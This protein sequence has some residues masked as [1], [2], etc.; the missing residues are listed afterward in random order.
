MDF[1]N[2]FKSFVLFT[3]LIVLLSNGINGQVDSTL[4]LP[5]NVVNKT[6][7]QR[8]FATIAWNAP[9]NFFY[10]SYK[11]YY[12]KVTDANFQVQANIQ[13]YSYT[14]NYANNAY[15]TP[16]TAFI[17]QVAGVLADGRESTAVQVDP[18]KSILAPIDPKRDPTKGIQGTSCVVNVRNNVYCTWTPGVV[19]YTRIN[20]RV[21]CI[22]PNGDN[23]I[24]RKF[25]FASANRNFIEIYNTPRNSVC[26]ILVHPLYAAAFR[27]QYNNVYADRIRFTVTTPTG[28]PI[29]L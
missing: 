27:P 28:G 22:K 24:I 16:G 12:R 29:F 7:G 25:V 10:P 1:V 5:I 15:I 21:K 11:L 19:P 23:R 26:K 6:P 9:A 4:P 18:T 14:L 3:I 17:F 13:G 20:F 8:T 2:S